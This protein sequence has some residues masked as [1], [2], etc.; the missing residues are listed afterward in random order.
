MKGLCSLSG[1]RGVSPAPI[2][3]CLS[4]RSSACL[5]LELASFPQPHGSSGHCAIVPTS[6]SPFP[7]TRL[8]Y[9]PPSVPEH[10]LL[11]YFY[12]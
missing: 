5:T 8:K 12:P 7:L 10:F 9:R 3:A 2:S 6:E 11:F 1:L 4:T